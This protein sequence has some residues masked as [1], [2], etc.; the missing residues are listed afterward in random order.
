MYYAHTH[1]HAHMHTPTHT[2]TPVGTAHTVAKINPWQETQ[3][4]GKWMKQEF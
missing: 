2:H 3:R 4:G 1:T